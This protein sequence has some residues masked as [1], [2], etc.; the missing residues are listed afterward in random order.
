MEEEIW[1]DIPWYE[2][3]YQASSLWNIK[4]LIKHNWTN[5]RILKYYLNSWGYQQLC[6]YKNKQPKTVSVHRLVAQAFISN[7]DNKKE[8]N[9]KNWFKDDNRVENLEWVTPS[10]N[11]LHKYNV[12]WIKCPAQVNHHMKWKLWKLNPIIKKVN[13]YDL[14]WN[15]IQT[16]YWTREAQRITWINHSCI[17]LCCRWKLK[18]SWWYI[19]KYV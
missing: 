3:Y 14:N 13:Q 19:W 18:T 1:K 10:E 16:F 9:H 11:I 7:P 12:L 5:N 6:L 17:S 15:F 4:S 2:W 8:V